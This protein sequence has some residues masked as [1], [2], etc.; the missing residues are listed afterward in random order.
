MANLATFTGPGGSDPGASIR[1]TIH[2]LSTPTVGDQLY[3][4]Q[5][6]RSRIRQRTLSGVDV[7]GVPFAPYST[8]GPY[9]FYP[10]KEAGSVRG[11]SGTRR[12]TQEQV[13]HARSTAAKNRQAKIGAPGVRTPYGIRYASYAAAKAAHG[14]MGVNLYGMEQ[15]THMLDTMLVKAGGSEINQAS[16]DLNF[17]SQFSSFEQNTPETLLVIGFYGPEAERAKGNNEGTSKLP[18]REFFALN[19]DDLRL[20]EQAIAERMMDRAQSGSGGH[21]TSASKVSAARGSGPITLSDV[22]F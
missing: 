2:A 17:G 9:Y 14:A 11:G 19:P 12:L 7:N 18:K 5:I 22:G 20:A 1:A 16:G 15:H 6:F 21:T 10:N 13:R 4:G 3:V 8:N